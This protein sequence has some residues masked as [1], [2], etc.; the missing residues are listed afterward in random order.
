MLITPLTTKLSG[1]IVLTSLA[2][3]AA[4]EFAYRMNEK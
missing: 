2:A 3:V 1:V 4:I